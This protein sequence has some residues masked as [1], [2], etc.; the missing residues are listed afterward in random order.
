[1]R[2]NEDIDGGG[3]KVAGRSGAHVV[4]LFERTALL[5]PALSHGAAEV[6]TAHDRIVAEGTS[7]PVAALPVPGR[8]GHRPART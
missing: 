5:I 1:M 7:Y 6:L 8:R 3:G 4:D 2:L